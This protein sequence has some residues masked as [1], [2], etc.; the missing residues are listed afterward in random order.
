L[1]IHVGDAKKQVHELIIVISCKETLPDH[2]HLSHL[3]TL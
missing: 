2:I 3:E 1:L